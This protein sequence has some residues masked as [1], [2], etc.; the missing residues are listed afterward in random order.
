MQARPNIT[1]R[2]GIL[3]MVAVALQS[4][5]LGVGFRYKDTYPQELVFDHGTAW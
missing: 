4:T 2:V 3:W 5:K 1:A